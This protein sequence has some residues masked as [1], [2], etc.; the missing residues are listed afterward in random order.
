MYIN[1]V[2]EGWEFVTYSYKVLREF[3]KSVL[4]VTDSNEQSPWA[5]NGCSLCKEIPGLLW[6]P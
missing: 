4:Y 3:L 6:N 5:A 2:A 1:S